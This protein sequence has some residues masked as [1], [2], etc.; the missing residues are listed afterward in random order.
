MDFKY[1]SEDDAEMAYKDMLSRYVVSKTLRQSLMAAY[2]IWKKNEGITFWASRKVSS[3][4]EYTA[5]EL[6][7]EGK[8]VVKDLIRN[9]SITCTI[10]SSAS[11]NPTQSKVK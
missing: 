5:G 4:L 10:K 2:D 1:V 8:Y 11:E 6:A 9:N 7:S 3:S